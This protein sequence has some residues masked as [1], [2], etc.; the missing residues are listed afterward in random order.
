[1]PRPTPPDERVITRRR[2]V[3]EQIRR[4]REKHNMSQQDV[5]G[6]SGIDVATY[7]RIEQGHSSPKLDTLIRIADAI[8]VPLTH[9]VD[10]RPPRR[11]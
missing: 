4:V 8:G 11:L 7:S 6:R 9:L 5:C 1:M 2:Q 10:V 3:G